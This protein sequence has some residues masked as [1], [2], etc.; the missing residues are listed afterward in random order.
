MRDRSRS[1]VFLAYVIRLGCSVWVLSSSMQEVDPDS[2]SRP[3]S[4]DGV[5]MSCNIADV[6]TYNALISCHEACDLCGRVFI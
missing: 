1:M 3:G 4:E 5:A 2:A 6:D